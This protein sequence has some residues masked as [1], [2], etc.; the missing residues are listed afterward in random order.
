M[1]FR[2]GTR[3][4][5]QLRAKNLGVSSSAQ[6]KVDHLVTRSN[7]KHIESLKVDGVD[8]FIWTKQRKGAFCSCSH[9]NNFTA[10]KEKA[11]DDDKKDAF[12]SHGLNS[13]KLK[14]MRIEQKSRFR[15]V[16][17]TQIEK[18][19][20]KEKKA[21]GKTTDPDE[22]LELWSDSEFFSKDQEED[23]IIG[24]SN[25]ENLFGGE[26]TLCA[27][28]FG[29]GYVNGYDLFNGQ[30]IIL[31][32][33]A[34][35]SCS[36]GVFID[37]ES[38]PKAFVVP[39]NNNVTFTAELPGYFDKLTR[40]RVM[41]NNK[42]VPSSDYV[43]EYQPVSG[44]IL[45]VLD[46]ST[47]GSRVG[48]TNLLYV[49]I[50]TSSDIKFSHIE[51][52]FECTQRVRLQMPDLSISESLDHFEPLLTTNFELPSNVPMMRQAFIN[53]SKYGRVWKISDFTQSKTASGKIF[54]LEASGRM[55]HQFEI[56][57]LLNM[58]KASEDVYY[59]GPDRV[60]NDLS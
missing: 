15:D 1:T 43:L 36:S 45:T 3:F 6:Q 46:L 34:N 20:D 37:L 42:P 29:T 4:R 40:I 59:R 26:Q 19:V 47:F 25:S 60:Q 48:F 30:R 27:I 53:E 41:Q 50:T 14:P 12:N 8:A 58:F 24:N 51:L 54:K 18:D 11:P 22:D 17:T 7:E 39:I 16:P 44:G 57:N 5:P 35:Y 38:R 56:G 13:I 52:I 49:K 21:L 10:L 55:L 23:G 2:V 32:S 9:Q 33:T 28:C 31:D